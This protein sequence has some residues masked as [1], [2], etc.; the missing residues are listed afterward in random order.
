MKDIIEG[1]DELS[2]ITTQITRNYSRL[3]VI[4]N[5]MGNNTSYTGKLSAGTNLR[6]ER[7]L[8]LH[9]QI[10]EDIECCDALCG[11]L[12]SDP[13][14]YC[15]DDE[16]VIRVDSRLRDEELELYALE[17]KLYRVERL[18]EKLGVKLS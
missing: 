6:V 15:T 9:S 17:K 1:W 2:M 10:A 8:K 14:K 5:C 18:L 16:D 3:Q 12:C 4:Y 11:D 13:Y 7:L